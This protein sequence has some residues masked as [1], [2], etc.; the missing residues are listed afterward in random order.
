MGR[1]T[2][3]HTIYITTREGREGLCDEM[4]ENY[5]VFW[6]VET[7]KLTGEENDKAHS[8][9]WTRSPG[10]G[11]RIVDKTDFKISPTSAMTS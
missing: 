9:L 11:T 2:L 3:R 6:F 4:N 1:H 10:C 8:S 7:E 5:V